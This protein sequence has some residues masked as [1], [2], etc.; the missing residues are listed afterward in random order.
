VNSQARDINELREKITQAGMPQE[1]KEKAD[2]E[3]ERMG[4]MPNASPEVSVVRT[5]LDWLVSLPWVKKTTDNLDI[6]AAAKL[7]DEHHYGLKKAKEN[8][9]IYRRAEI[10]GRKCAHL[11][12]VSSDRPEPARR[13]WGDRYQKR[14]EG[15]LFASPSAAFTTK[16]R[17]VGIVEPTSARFPG[18]LFKP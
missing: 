14:W 11:F 3:L 5:Y 6:P 13:L 18:E 1:V 17:F 9:G 15:T 7:L 10:G 16:P 8:S 12:F 4:Q 2:H